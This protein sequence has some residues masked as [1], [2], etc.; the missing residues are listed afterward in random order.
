MP[1]RHIDRFGF[2]MLASLATYGIRSLPLV[3][4]L[5]LQKCGL[6]RVL[7]SDQLFA[8]CVITSQGSLVVAGWRS[9]DVVRSPACDAVSS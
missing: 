9:T 1:L 3:D 7:S 2:Q 5:L 6:V 4:G 8:E